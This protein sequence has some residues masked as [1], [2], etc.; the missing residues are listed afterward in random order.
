MVPSRSRRSNPA[1]EERDAFGNAAPALDIVKIARACGV[2]SV[3][4][5]GPQD[6]NEDLRETFRAALAEESLT[7]C[8]V[9]LE[10]R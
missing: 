6:L 3:Y 5:N 2:S 10:S 9:R 1:G 8:H 7:L 4:A